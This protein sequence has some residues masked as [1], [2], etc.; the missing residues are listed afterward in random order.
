MPGYCGWYCSLFRTLRWLSSRYAYLPINNLSFLT[1]L[2]ILAAKV[3]FVSELIEV[4]KRPADNM[5]VRFFWRGRK[6]D[7]SLVVSTWQDWGFSAGAVKHDWKARRHRNYYRIESDDN[8]IY[9]IY[10]DRQ[11]SGEPAWYLY[12]I[13]SAKPGADLDS[14]L[15][16]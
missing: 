8:K 14:E 16:D 11:T 3:V 13:I 5:P 9:E 12:R 6:I 10:L 1:I 7:I 4:V 15:A 2:Y